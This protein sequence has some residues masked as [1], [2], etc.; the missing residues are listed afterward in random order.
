M[1]KRVII[2]SDLSGE[3][4]AETVSFAFDGISYTVDL[5]E[6]EKEEFAK[7]LSPYLDVAEE[8]TTTTGQQSIPTQPQSTGPDPSTV[9]AWAQANG[10]EVS[11]KG[12]VPHSVVA[13]YVKAQEESADA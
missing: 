1:A 8:A 7:L 10:I 5:T 2:E 4:D 12:R 11:A 6:G 3:P 9:R 13:Q